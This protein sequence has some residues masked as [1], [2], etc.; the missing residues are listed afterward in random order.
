MVVWSKWGNQTKVDATH[1]NVS[2]VFIVKVLDFTPN[3]NE[4]GTSTTL[5]FTKVKYDVTGRSRSE[6]RGRTHGVIDG[7]EYLP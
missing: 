1:I 7:Q 2:E 5:R 4:I 3:Q 6:W